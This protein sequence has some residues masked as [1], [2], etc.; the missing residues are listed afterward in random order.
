MSTSSRVGVSRRF[1]RKSKGARGSGRREP[2]RAVTIYVS[3][4][5]SRFRRPFIVVSVVRTFRRSYVANHRFCGHGQST[6]PGRRHVSKQRTLLLSTMAILM[7]DLPQYLLVPEGTI[8]LN[9]QLEAWAA[10]PS[11]IIL[12]ESI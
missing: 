5:A 4:R 8:S 12:R 7:P 3:S 11:R 9:L 6:I 10:S 1:Q 2:P